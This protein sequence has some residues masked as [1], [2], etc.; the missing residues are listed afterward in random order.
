MSCTLVPCV[1]FDR[2]GI[3]NQSPGP[4]YVEHVDDFH[5]IPAFIDAL[6]IVKKHHRLAIVISN[7]RGVSRGIM[8]AKTVDAIHDKLQR[9][10]QNHGL[11]MDAIYY[12]PHN[13]N[14][15]DCRKPKP[16]MLLRASE[17]W[18]ID[19]AHS[20]MVGDSESDVEAGHR[21]GC[22]TVRV[23]PDASQSAAE[24]RIHEMQE[25]PDLLEKL[26]AGV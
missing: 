16:G 11:A 25:L 6:R 22:R 5:L 15:C 26:L 23:H 20:L 10:L 14:E 24:Y 9:S 18:H 1:F 13:H 3:I 17:D 21:A 2:D 7:Q 19:L 8:S 4:G 12:C